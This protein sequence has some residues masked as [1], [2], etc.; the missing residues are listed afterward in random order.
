MPVELLISALEIRVCTCLAA[1]EPFRVKGRQRFLLPSIIIAPALV[2]V[3][4]TATN[5]TRENVFAA[6]LGSVAVCPESAVFLSPKRAAT[7]RLCL[8]AALCDRGRTV[9][10]KRT[11]NGPPVAM[12]NYPCFSWFLFPPLNQTWLCPSPPPSCPLR[13]ESS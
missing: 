5:S 1:V 6:V 2:H 13:W 10:H 3:L 9:M 12:N 4:H 8:V 11:R 7:T